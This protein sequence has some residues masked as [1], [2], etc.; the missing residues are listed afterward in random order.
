MER[1]GI[2]VGLN[3]GFIVTKPSGKTDLKKSRK[4]RNWRLGKRV[5]LIRE[6]VREVAGFAPYEKKMLELIRTGNAGKEKRAQK[7]A[8]QRLGTLRRAKAKKA[9]LSNI[10]QM[11]K[12]AN[13]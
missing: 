7:V 6:V 8:K 10:V 3:K 13:K 12:R 11:Q 5:Q 1:S 4:S 9:E 2:F